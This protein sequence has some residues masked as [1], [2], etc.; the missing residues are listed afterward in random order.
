MNVIILAAGTGARMKNLTKKKPKCFLKINGT[1]LIERLVTQLKKLGLKDISIIVGYKAESFFFKDVNYFYNKKYSNTNM[2]YSLM[3]A[4]KKMNKDT[5]II[6]SDVLLSKNILKKML[7]TKK[8][9]A[10]G[11]DINWK[12]YWKFRFKKINSDLESLK[13]NKQNHVLEIGRETK[14]LKDI[15]ARYIGIIKTSKNINKKI[16]SVWEKEKDRSKPN[17]GISGNSLN[18]AYMTDLINKIINSNKKKTICHAIKFK[19]GW[20]EFD[21]KKDFFNFKNYKDKQIHF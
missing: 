5:L 8:E 1:T 7:K 11:V 16:I 9:F 18:K 12:K 17:W 14:D 21:N 4:K 20:Y 10:V 6:Y 13:M 19:N 15:N 2:F 3:K